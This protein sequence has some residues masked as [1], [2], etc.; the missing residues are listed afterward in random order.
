VPDSD[1]WSEDS[2]VYIFA[3]RR[4]NFCYIP[5][6]T[7]K[8][9][10]VA[11]KR[12]TLAVLSVFLCSAAALAQSTI[13]LRNSNLR[14][15][16]STK[17]KILKTLQANSRVTI[18]SKYPREG[19]VRVQT[20]D[21]ARVGWLIEKNISSDAQ[22]AVTTLSAPLSLTATSK[23]RPGDPEIYPDS[24]M[25]PRAPDPSFTQDN[26]AENICNKGWTTGEVRPSTSVT[27]KIKKQTMVAYGFTDSPTHYELDHLI[28]LQDG[29][30]PDF[31][32]NLWPESYGDPSHQVT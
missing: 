18:I 26:I 1:E 31:V 30:C 32:V 7:K 8:L 24:K 23:S 3:R 27:S 15:G 17:S 16:P 21:R 5:C 13:L 2:F 12:C 19:Y 9:E 28:S 4:L 25:T 10:R 22:L 11:M 14:S 20:A 6:I 29:G